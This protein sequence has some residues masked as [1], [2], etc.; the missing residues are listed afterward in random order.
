MKKG[1]YHIHEPC[2]CMDVSDV[3]CLWACL[4]FVCVCMR[5]MQFWQ[6]I[7]IDIYENPNSACVQCTLLQY[8]LSY[9]KRLFQTARDLQ[10]QNLN[11]CSWIPVQPLT[12]RVVKY[13]TAVSKHFNNRRD[14]WRIRTCYSYITIFGNAKKINFGRGQ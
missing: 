13:L 1:V 4:I 12:R 3:W 10:L 8:Q 11:Y 9:C 7:L 14:L 2:L 6:H 5:V